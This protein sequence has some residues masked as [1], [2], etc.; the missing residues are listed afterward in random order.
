VEEK[1]LYTTTEAAKYLGISQTTLNR[2][3]N[4]G[5][6]IATKDAVT[7]QTAFEKFELDKLRQRVSEAKQT[8]KS[9]KKASNSSKNASHSIDSSD[10]LLQLT[11]LSDAVRD[12][13]SKQDELLKLLRSK[14][15]ASSTSSLPQS[16]SPSTSSH[17]KAPKN[18]NGHQS[19]AEYTQKLLQNYESDDVTIAPD[20]LLA[21]LLDRRILAMELDKAWKLRDDSKQ[22][23]LKTL[24]HHLA[25]ETVDS[26]C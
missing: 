17:P 14:S 16:S 1:L 21:H 2:W 26:E 8:P 25:A 11:Q 18:R 7:G 6:V 15:V 13:Q 10:L 22:E 20:Q 4:Q 19:A 3:Q 5:R 24:L 23:W 9:P 12:I